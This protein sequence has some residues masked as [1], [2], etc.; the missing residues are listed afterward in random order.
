MT[1]HVFVYLHVY[2]R[3]RYVGEGTEERAMK[4]VRYGKGLYSLYSQR[5]RKE[6]V[7]KIVVGKYDNKVSAWILEQGMISWIGMRIREEGP[8]MNSTS[9][10]S[11]GGMA[12]S[13]PETIERKRRRILRPMSLESR[14]KGV[15]TRKASGTWHSKE[16]IRKIADKNKGR[17]VSKETRKRISDSLTGRESPKEVRE[18]ISEKAKQQYREGRENPMKKGVVVLFLDGTKRS[19]KSQTEAGEFLGITPQGVARIVKTGKTRLRIKSIEV[20]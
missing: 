12:G 18:K 11:A 17:K 16:T 8:L 3:P 10:T 20:L 4:T 7:C 14:K 2:D 13:Y 6:H 15:E 19:F 9:F 5:H 1:K